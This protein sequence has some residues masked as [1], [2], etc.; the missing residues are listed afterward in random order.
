VP[1][2]SYDI[3]GDIEL[4]EGVTGVLN[5][6]LHEQKNMATVTWHTWK[7]L[8]FFRISTSDYPMVQPKNERS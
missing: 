4:Q 3:K 1:F 6:S 5:A 2:W 7:N 8:L